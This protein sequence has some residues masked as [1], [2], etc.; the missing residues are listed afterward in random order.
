VPDD[1]DWP[2]RDRDEQAMHQKT[3]DREDAQTK[4]RYTL[5]AE[6]SPAGEK[7]YPNLECLR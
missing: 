4:V 5:G 6:S 3:A 2:R 1:D 7:P